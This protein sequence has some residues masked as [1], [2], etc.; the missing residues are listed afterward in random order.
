MKRNFKSII[1]R[2]TRIYV[3]VLGVLLVAGLTARLLEIAF[4]AI[5]HGIWIFTASD[6]VTAISTD[7]LLVILFSLPLSLV[8]YLLRRAGDNVRSLTVAIVIGLATIGSL[9]LSLYYTATL[10]P[11]GPE[12]WAYSFNEM[13]DTVMAAE[14]YIELKLAFLVLLTI[15]FVILLFYA[16]KRMARF[17]YHVRVV[18]ISS[19]FA[20]ATLGTVLLLFLQDSSD[21]IA[22][23]K[24]GYFVMSGFEETTEDVADYKPIVNQTLA[25]ENSEFP[26]LKR[27]SEND[28][29]GPFFKEMSDPPNI[30][31]ILVESLGGEFV[32]S[33]G[34]WTGFAPFIDSL[35]ANGLYWENGLSMSGRTFGMIPSLLGSLPPGNNGFMDLGPEYP[36]HTSLIRMLDEQ[37]YHTS[38]YSGYNT[39]FD[40][41]NYFLDY[42]GTDVIINKEWIT[43]NFGDQFKTGANYW[44]YDDKSMLEIAGSVVDSLALR[45][46]PRLEIYH[47]LQSHSPFT[48]PDEQ[49]YA[50]RFNEHLEELSLPISK[51][52]AFKR[53]RSELTTL[54]FTDD[55]LRDFMN[56]YKKRD[57]YS[58][59]LFI[60]TGDHWLIPVPQTSRVSRYHVPIIFYS[61]LIEK[62]AQFQSVNT[63]AN[64]V[65]ALTTLID[66]N[67]GLA[68]PDSVHWIGETMDTLRTF[69]NI[70]SLPMMQN[71]NQLSDYISGN[72]FLSDNTLYRVEEGLILVQEPN[73]EV[74]N[75]LEQALLRFKSKNSYVTENNKLYPEFF[76]D[77]SSSDYEFITRFSVMFDE[78]DTNS[79]SVDEQFKAARDYAFE[80]D[81]DRARAIAKRL[82]LEV[83]DYHDIRIF[84]GR[85]HAWNR[86][87]E[88]AREY[89]HEVQRRDSTYNDTYNA[90]ADTEYWSGNYSVA[91]EVIN[92]GLTFH[93]VN[94]SFLQKKINILIA[95]DRSGEAKITFTE[96]KKAHPSNQNI[97]ELEN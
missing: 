8:F 61:D 74:K 37:G 35:A 86:E 30:V 95:L 67:T 36:V 54:L 47:T 5:K 83:P 75:E 11:L 14:S 60:I 71:K 56:V 17:P 12:F 91:L 76:R 25:I 88:K 77:E 21:S 19:A 62:P 93:P 80:S 64:I 89:L 24:L 32:G 20:L 39:Y 59:T 58:N 18:L 46:D 94:E 92:T 40:G 41:L 22:Y 51:Q 16:I 2:F 73:S 49:F 27:S 72:H 23:N 6:I 13:A 68:L 78:I 50:R 29:L 26:L 66:S 43:S 81:Y 85:T 57:S 84:L 31:F 44:G 82:L 48:L 52:E 9:L 34:N 45:P 90:L 96:L 63:H 15:C 69:R 3:P 97:D 4:V 28:V 55:A 87:Y 42:Q 79:L 53:Y 7:I 1:D 33:S 65:P 38:F 70:H 10:T